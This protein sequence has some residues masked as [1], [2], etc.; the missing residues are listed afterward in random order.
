MSISSSTFQSYGF[1]SS[2][3]EGI[4]I[5]YS[6]S[7]A[8]PIIDYIDQYYEYNSADNNEDTVDFPYGFKAPFT[9]QI[10][11]NLPPWMA[12]RKDYNSNG[13]QLVNAWGMHLE[14]TLDLYNIYRRDQFLGTANT[15]YDI[16]ALI[17]PLSSDKN[18]VYSPT[19]NNLLFN[20]SFSMEATSREQRPL[21]WRAFRSVKDAVKFDS[22][23]SIFGSHSVVLDGT[24]GTSDL[25][26]TRELSIPNGSL[27]YS[28]F[29]KTEDTGEDTEESWDASEAGIILVVEFLDSTIA[30]YGVGFKKNTLGKWTRASLTVSLTKETYRVSSIIVNKKQVSYKVHCPLLERSK[31]LGQWTSSVNDI[32]PFLATSIRTVMGVQ[33]FFDSPDGEAARKIEIHPVDSEQLF[34]NIAIPTRIIPYN[35]T[36]PTANSFSIS[37]GRHVN[38]FEEVMP[39]T[40]TIDNG[41]L[42]E[43]SL[44]T[45]DRFGSRNIADATIDEYG[46]LSLDISLVNSSSIVPKAVCVYE[47]KLLVVTKE[48]YLGQDGYYLKFALPKYLTHEDSYIPSFGDLKI[49]IN[50]G[51]S[52]GLSAI[53]EDISR[54]GICK[55]I[56]NVIYIDTTLDRRFYFKLLFDY[57][58]SDFNTRKIFCRENYTNNFGLLQII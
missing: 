6:Y 46:N 19:F 3:A 27:T 14:N 18:K 22:S 21:G 17:T 23:D 57:Y 31:T 2:I 48:T 51:Q 1:S 15:Y 5:V 33:V 56:P 42:L 20:S 29:F 25:K 53:S 8:D 16:K 12:M 35:K 39:T 30:T 34:K 36:A 26:Q 44:S 10:L 4:E 38:F 52:F 49:P 43:S 7:V 47:D 45:P 24:L 54:I 11:N 58:Y 41:L 13:N 50:L 40:W 32:N 55:N 37:Y 28:I 9:Q